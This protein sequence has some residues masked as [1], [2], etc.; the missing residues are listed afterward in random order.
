MVI[1]KVIKEVDSG[2]SVDIDTLE[3]PYRGNNK[4]LNLLRNSNW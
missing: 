2:K 4:N 3:K 1:I